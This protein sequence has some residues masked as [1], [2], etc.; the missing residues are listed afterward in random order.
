MYVRMNYAKTIENI[1]SN[2][3]Y[4]AAGKVRTLCVCDA[5]VKM[6]ILDDLMRSN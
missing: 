1:L 2:D 6:A 4:L 3:T 5:K